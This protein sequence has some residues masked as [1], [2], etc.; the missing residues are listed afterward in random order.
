MWV[1]KKIPAD[2]LFPIS[3]GGF[4]NQNAN[5]GLGLDLGT[6]VVSGQVNYQYTPVVI[7]LLKL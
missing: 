4:I 5:I 2:I 6:T 1:V 7:P 3:G